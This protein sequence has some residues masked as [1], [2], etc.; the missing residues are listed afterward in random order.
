MI[1]ATMYGLHQDHHASDFEDLFRL[2]E[3]FEPNL[4]GVEIRPED[5]GADEDYLRANYPHEMIELARRHG[6]SAFGFD[7]LGD[8]IAGRYQ[9][10]AH[11]Y[12]RRDREI[13]ERLNKVVRENPGR[14]II[15]L[16]GADH[17]GFAEA[18]LREALGSQIEIVPVD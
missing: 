1:V 4:V 13:A 2:V 9:Q 15:F 7:W 17:R 14:R 16:T 11:F 18:R 8:D 3:N 5:V 10:L 6:E 12:A